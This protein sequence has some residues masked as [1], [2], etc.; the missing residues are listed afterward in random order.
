MKKRGTEKE[1]RR[2]GL[3]IVIEFLNADF[4]SKSGKRGRWRN[5]IPRYW[6]LE[7]AREI[8]RHIIEAHSYG[9][10]TRALHE[11]AIEY[12]SHVQPDPGP[13]RRTWKLLNDISQPG[14]D[15]MT[16]IINA[17]DSFWRIGRCTREPC[18]RFF[19]PTRKRKFC[20]DSCQ[21]AFN[22]EGAQ[23]RVEQAR[24]SHRYKEIKDQLLKLQKLAKRTPLFDILR[25]LPGF[26]PELLETIIVA[27]RS[28]KSLASDIKYRN[29][30]ILME[31][32]L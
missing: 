12:V 20:S 3:S 19:L 18:R 30:K 2:Y 24:Q 29:R 8:Q 22:N 13:D 25:L 9:K 16:A 11:D 21:T 32:K 26:S 23:D 6:S 7:Q 14:S 28:L 10:I 5:Y 31:A 1:T 27:K 15:V 17:D 4:S